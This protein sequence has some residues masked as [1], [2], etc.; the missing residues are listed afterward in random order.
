MRPGDPGRLI[1]E[2]PYSPERVAA[3]KTVPGRRWHPDGRYWSVPHTP[4]MP[5]LLATT[6]APEPVEFAAPLTPQP[7]RAAA[8]SPDPRRN[9]LLDR[10]RAALRA[11]HLSPRT[12]EAYLGWA[13]RFL[14]ECRAQPPQALGEEEV[15]CFLTA[16]AVEARV[17]ASTQ[18][19]AL[20]ALVFFFREALGRRLGFVKGVVRAKM[21]KRLP[22]VLDRNE[23]GKILSHMNGPTRL[24]AILLYGGGLRLL[25]C[26]RLR[27]K[28]LDFPAHSIVVREGKGEKDRWTILPA[29]ARRELLGHLASV[30][31]QHEQDLAQGLGSVAVPGA[32]AG[33]E[34][35]TSKEWG[36]QWVFPSPS[37]RAGA[38]GR[39][40]LH[41]TVLQRAFRE[42]RLK[43]G[44]AKPASC[45][46]LRHSFATHLLEDGYDIRRVQELLGHRS[47]STTMIYVHVMNTG[48][49]ARSPADKPEAKEE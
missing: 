41:K 34:P 49:P 18:N 5:R 40:H 26:C 8:D 23:V 46:T 4:N 35:A 9:L 12:E 32:I 33:Q 14:R 47:A 10:A 37:V 3:I 11:R 42:A 13:S 20:N 19:Q 29:S 2:L 6:F 7:E 15:G 16:L 48:A 25:E 30:R 21:P 38:R 44:I 17:S 45:H 28:D 22:V 24:M 39:R 1:V 31:R 43:A 27:I 36:W